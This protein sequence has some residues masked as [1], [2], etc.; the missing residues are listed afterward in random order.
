MTTLQISY[1]A[2]KDKKY[3][4]KGITGAMSFMTKII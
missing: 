2:H 4:I 3:I 1:K